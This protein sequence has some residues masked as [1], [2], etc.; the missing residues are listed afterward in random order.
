LSYSPNLKDSSTQE[1]IETKTERERERE[2][3]YFERANFVFFIYLKKL[4]L[5]GFYS[6]SEER[7]MGKDS[8]R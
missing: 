7:R 3:E 8:K 5:I 6:V 2:R 4:I 1:G